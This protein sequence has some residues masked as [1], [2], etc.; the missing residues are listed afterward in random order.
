M[1]EDQLERVTGGKP[2]IH[3]LLQGTFRPPSSFLCL[4][5]VKNVDSEMWK[6]LLCPANCSWSWCLFC[7]CYRRWGSLIFLIWLCVWDLYHHTPHWHGLSASDRSTG[8]TTGLPIDEIMTLPPLVIL[9]WRFVCLL[10]ESHSIKSFRQWYFSCY[11][12]FTR[13]ELPSNFKVQLLGSIDRRKE[14]GEASD[15]HIC[16][17]KKPVP[18]PLLLRGYISQQVVFLVMTMTCLKRFSDNPW[19]RSW[20]QQLDHSAFDDAV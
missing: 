3:C 11:G 6:N 8:L 17:L 9:I 1:N 16:N 12:V 20:Q 7:F 19:R 15:T 18:F 5:P 10:W 13:N 14:E 4:S 2:N